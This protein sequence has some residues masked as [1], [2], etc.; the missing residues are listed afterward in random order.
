MKVEQTTLIQAKPE[1][2]WEAWVSEINQWWTA[3]YYNDKSK[4]SGLEFEPHLG[5][6]FIE[7]WD[8][9]GS[10]FLIGHIVEWL[11]PQRLA[12]TW[13]ERTWKGIV[14]LV[15][16]EFQ[17]E[18]HNTLLRL[19]HAGFERLPEGEKLR[20]GYADGHGKLVSRLKN[21]LERV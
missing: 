2:V 5:G 4:V 12:Y 7:K 19:V 9:D 16:L 11:P 18:G 17:L 13:S 20:S 14:T 1:R 15:S 8:E 10:G 21:Y 3:P 6:R